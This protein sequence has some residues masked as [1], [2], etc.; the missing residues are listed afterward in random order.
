MIEKH[1][2]DEQFLS[3]YGLR[4]TSADERMYCLDGTSNPSNNL[5]PI[6]LLHNY[7]PFKGLLNAGRKDLAKDLCY[8]LINVMA[9]DIAKTGKV[10]ECYSPDTGDPIM[11]HSFLSWNTLIIKM[12]KE[13]K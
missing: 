8:R 13:I 9:D 6:W 11:E 7:I 12:L 2:L 1:F 3:P 4:S 5:G 10:S